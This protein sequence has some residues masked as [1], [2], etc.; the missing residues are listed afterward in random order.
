MNRNYSS[1]PAKEWPRKMW[2]IGFSNTTLQRINSYEVGNDNSVIIFG[3]TC[4]WI[5]SLGEYMKIDEGYGTDSLAFIS[6]QGVVLRKEK[7]IFL[8]QKV[9]NGMRK[10]HSAIV[11]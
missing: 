3:D 1:N 6:D 8:Y 4:I 10:K 7:N 9:G 2:E 5:S 11:P